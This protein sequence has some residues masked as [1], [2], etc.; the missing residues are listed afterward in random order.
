MSKQVLSS[1]NSFNVTAKVV[2]FDFELRGET[3]FTCEISIPGTNYHIYREVFYTP[4]EPQHQRS[5]LSSGKT[6][7]SNPI[8]S[9]LM[10]GIFFLL[11][12]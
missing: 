5:V 9:L 4:G 12:I 8:L 6:Q 7:K 1:G 3:I 2:L 10:L 11:K